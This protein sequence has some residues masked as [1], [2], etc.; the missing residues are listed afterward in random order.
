[1]FLDN[2]S[3]KNYDIGLMSWIGDYIDPN[4]FLTTMLGSSGNNRT[5]WVNAQYD[6]LVERANDNPDRSARF[7]RLGEAERILLDDQPIVPF[8]HLTRSYLIHPAVR[9]YYPNML[10]L[11]PY[12]DI[13]FDEDAR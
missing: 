2:L 10:D 8:W 4:T 11:H 12:Q 6:A 1:V 3:A 5:G 13:W 9:G 7:L